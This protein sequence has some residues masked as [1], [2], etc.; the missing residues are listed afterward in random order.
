MP[1]PLHAVLER[2][3]DDAELFPPRSRPMADALRDHAEALAG[4]HGRVVGPFLCPATRL[5]EL[6]ALVASGLPRPPAVGVVGYDTFGGWRP[7]YATPGLVHVE[8]PQSARVPPPPGRVRR[9]VEIA[10]GADLDRALDAVAPGDGVKVRGAGPGGSPAAGIDWLTRLLVGCEARRLVVKA[11]GGF[12]QPYRT[13]DDGIVRHGFVNLLAASGLARSRRPASQV[14]AALATGEDRAADL[15][16]LVS[17]CRELL[18]SVSVPSLA[19]A[20]HALAAR[21]LL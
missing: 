19:Q 14:A 20:L 5:A 13:N 4:P 7:V 11:G 16:P 15:L 1:S 18:A 8:A 2:L 3:F 10:A 17:G 12:D 6:D 9:Y 21:D